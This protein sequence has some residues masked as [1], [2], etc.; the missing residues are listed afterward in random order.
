MIS[1]DEEDHKLIASHTWRLKKSGDKLYVSTPIYLG[2]IDGK[3]KWKH[4]YLHR[5]IMSAGKGQYV[6]HK[7]GDTLDN[8]KENLR[9]CTN[10]Q[11]CFNQKIRKNNKT[12]VKGVRLVKGK[13][14]AQININK[15]STYLGQFDSIDEAAECYK[16]KAKQL[17][18]EFYRETLV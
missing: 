7:N 8:R 6:D 11:N 1:F 4:V 16:A 9:I 14:I 2:K 15:K 13:Y 17:H 18:Q 12:G 5:L 10:Q 3:F